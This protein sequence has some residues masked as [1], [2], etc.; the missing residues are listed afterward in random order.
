MLGAI[1]GGV[2][3]VVAKVAFEGVVGKTTL[4]AAVAFLASAPA[5]A[6]LASSIWTGFSH[7]RHKIRFIT[8]MQLL[9]AGLVVSIA[10]LPRSDIGLIILMVAAIGGRMCWAGVVTLRSTVWR[11]NYPRDARASLAAGIALLQAIMLAGASFVISRTLNHF[12]L[13]AVRVLYPIAAGSGVFG[14]L[15]Y[16]RLRMRGHMR[17][18]SAERAGPR[19]RAFATIVRAPVEV[20]RVLKRDR[21]Y[22]RF[23][24]G[25]FTFGIGNLAVTGPLIIVL[26]EVFHFGYDAML[27]TATI[28]I[29]LIIPSVRIWSK[30]L[31]RMHIVSFRVIHVWIFVIAT[32]C[33]LIGTLTHT[34]ALIAIGAMCRGIGFGGGV[35][36][37][38]LGH[39]DFAPADQTSAYMNVHV[40]LTGVRGLI[41]PALAILGYRTLEAAG[42]HG[43]WIF[44]ACLFLNLIGAWIFIALKREMG[45]M[46]LEN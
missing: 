46:A 41:G 44:A 10:F 38:N 7:G 32:T 14:A 13:E 22:R 4:D 36:G 31:D 1:E 17:I 8:G 40:T 37:W 2:T 12:G 42:Y 43:A 29:L 9:A 30:V 25:M 26:D 21:R 6:N 5:F 33:F 45:D 28:P 3:G 18:L 11:V 23:M 27:F 16:M 19:P 15:V 24:L 20:V 39:H 34:T 35:L